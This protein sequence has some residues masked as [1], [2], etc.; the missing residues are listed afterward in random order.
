M[1][2]SFIYFTELYRDIRMKQELYCDNRQSDK[3]MGSEET[4]WQY[5]AM[6]CVN[7]CE[8]ALLVTRKATVIGWNYIKLIYNKYMTNVEK[9]VDGV[10][11]VRYR[12]TCGNTFLILMKEND[13]NFIRVNNYYYCYKEEAEKDNEVKKH[14]VKKHE[15]K[16]ELCTDVTE[17]VYPYAG[18]KWDFHGVCVSP[19]DIGFGH[20]YVEDMLN[21]TMSY[22]NHREAL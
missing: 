11:S 20:L 4:G 8:A 21:D 12:N 2:S 15:V 6:Q 3:E 5:H 7:R 16:C 18:P 19:R 10:R 1:L 13:D 22:V 14:E 9:G 17:D